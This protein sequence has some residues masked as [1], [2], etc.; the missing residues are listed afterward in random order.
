M[1]AAVTDFS[2]YTCI[3]RE[4]RVL[5]FCWVDSYIVVTESKTHLIFLVKLE[6]YLDMYKR[7][8]ETY[9]KKT[10]DGREETTK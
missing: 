7:E 10:L 1:K 8:M 4:V 5:L 2:F 9:S 3:T 6:K